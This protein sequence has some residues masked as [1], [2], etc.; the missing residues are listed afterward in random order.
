MKITDLECYSLLIP[1]FD[2]DA[3]SSAQDNLIVKIHTDE[4]L[5]GIG[6]TDTNPWGVKAIIDSPRSEEHTLTQSRRNLV[7]RLLL[8]KKKNTRMN[9]SITP[10]AYDG[11]CVHQ[12]L[13]RR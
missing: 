12:Y 3:C 8:E 6:E 4:G 2:A 5:I 9:S 10:I 13:S 1:D 7:C 11:F